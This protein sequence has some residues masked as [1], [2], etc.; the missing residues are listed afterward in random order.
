MESG[1]QTGV[2]YQASWFALR[3]KSHCERMTA[4]G[5]R[6]RGYEE[7]LPS[8]RARRRWSD[9]WVDLELPLFPGYVF[10]RFD[11]Q[12]RLPILKIPSLVHIVGIGKSPLPVDDGEIA[13]IQSIV[14][15]GLAAE[16]WPYLRVGDTV[17]VQYGALCGLEGILV[18]VKKRHRLVV[19]VTL[20]QRSVAVEIDRD[21]LS[22]VRPGMRIGMGAAAASLTA[23]GRDRLAA[24]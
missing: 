5:L 15:S 1:V 2:D 18:E 14:S 12:D 22:L 7:F 10:A 6:S 24:G 13:A 8:Y 21:W 23:T 19:S 4:A 16:P 3:V 9:R 20:L 11:P 17:R